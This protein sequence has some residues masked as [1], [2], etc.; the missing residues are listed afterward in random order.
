MLYGE[1]EGAL[2]QL[3]LQDGGAGMFPQLD[4]GSQARAVNAVLC[5]WLFVRAD[6][7]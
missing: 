5:L 4:S 3:S 2:E 6:S 1:P 7:A